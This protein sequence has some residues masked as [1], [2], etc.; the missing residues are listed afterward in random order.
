MVRLDNLFARWHAFRKE[1]LKPHHLITSQPHLTTL[2]L[3]PH[4]MKTSSSEKLYYQSPEVRVVQ[5]DLQTVLASSGNPTIT[6]P[7]M[8]WD[9]RKKNFPWEETE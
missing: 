4:F 9:T 3:N 7:P 1:T 2:P 8:Q 5:L 6:N